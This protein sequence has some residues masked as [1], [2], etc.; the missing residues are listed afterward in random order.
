MTV[1]SA[2]E[3]FG[4]GYAPSSGEH[5]SSRVAAHDLLKQGGA[6]YDLDNYQI[7]ANGAAAGHRNAGGNPDGLIFTG[8]AYIFDPTTGAF[9]N[10]SG[11]PDRPTS[12]IIDLNTG[13]LRIRR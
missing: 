13:A 9:A 8:S 11:S 12:A 5:L 4:G 6:R 2:V 3:P 10:V 1:A 7:V